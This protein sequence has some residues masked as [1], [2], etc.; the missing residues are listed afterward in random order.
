MGATGQAVLLESARGENRIERVEELMG[1]LPAALKLM[2]D[3][4]F[5][6]IVQ[7]AEMAL[8]G[9]KPMV[10]SEDQVRALLSGEF[11]TMPDRAGMLP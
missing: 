8:V 10:F 2:D 11:R 6:T 1:W 4:G 7:A 3:E 9:A 5:E